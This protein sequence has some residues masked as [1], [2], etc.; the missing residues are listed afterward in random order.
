MPRVI[1]DCEVTAIYCSH[2][3]E[4]VFSSTVTL[5]GNVIH[6]EFVGEALLPALDN[7]PIVYKGWQIAPGHFRLVG[8]NQGDIAT[9]HAFPNSRRLEGY[10]QENSTLG[11]W[12]V[13]LPEPFDTEHSDFESDREFSGPCAK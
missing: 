12:L 10:W 4:K 5:D 8:P 3:P 13:E 7:E 2:D 1:N 11:M 6:I 9:L